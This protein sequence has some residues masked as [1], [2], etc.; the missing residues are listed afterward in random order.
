LMPFNHRLDSL[1]AAI[2]RVK[3][4]HLD[5]LIGLRRQW[6]AKYNELLAGSGMVLPV[7]PPGYQHVYHL[8]VIR[9]QSRDALQ[10][11]LKDRGVGTAIHYP[12]PVHLQPFYSDGRDR[13]GEF[14]ISEQVCNEIVSVPMFPEMT[15][16]QVEY[17]A[18]AITRFA[19]ENM[20]QAAA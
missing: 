16:E 20:A 19:A 6:A 3:L 1:Q 7:E 13:H 9:T 12:N 5:E 17:V 18:E 15:E 11:Y 10:A 14:P 4:R 8:Y 2:L